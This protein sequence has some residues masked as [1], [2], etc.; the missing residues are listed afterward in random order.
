MDRVYE[1]FAGLLSKIV[2]FFSDKTDWFL[3]L[4]DIKSSY[5]VFLDIALVALLFYWAYLVFSRAHRVFWGL[6]ILIV[7]LALGKIFDFTTISWLSERLVLV[8]I[9]AIPIIFQPELREIL[10][11]MGGIRFR[12]NKEVLDKNQSKEKDL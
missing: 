3:S 9:V 12:K 1:T 5:L 7:V 6:T 10:E 4:K 8:F 2:G 11:K